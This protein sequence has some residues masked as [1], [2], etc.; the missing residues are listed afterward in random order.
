MTVNKADD[1]PNNSGK[2]IDF[3]QQ[4]KAYK[5]RNEVDLPFTLTQVEDSMYIDQYQVVTLEYHYY[6]N[7]CE[8]HELERCDEFV[9]PEG[10]LCS[11]DGEEAEHKLGT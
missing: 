11:I 5:E 4:L 9:N 6:Q 2:S 7:D 10:K 1:I 3:E 8:Y